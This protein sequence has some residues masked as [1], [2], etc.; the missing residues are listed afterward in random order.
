MS[1]GLSVFATDGRIIRRAP[2]PLPL[3]QTPRVA[4]VHRSLVIG[5]AAAV[6]KPDR[7][8]EGALPPGLT[9][10][11]DA[12]DA[13]LRAK[14][15]KALDDP[16][17]SVSDQQVMDDAQAVTDQKRN[18]RK[19]NREGALC[20]VCPDVRRPATMCIPVHMAAGRPRLRR[21]SDAAKP[22]TILRHLRPG[23]LLQEPIGAV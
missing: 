21:S 16:R 17:P 11:P 4:I 6:G 20:P 9:A 13:W 18:A 5:E 8:D 2:P 7:Q 23:L 12:Y 22:F 10:D 15:Q 19:L 3:V 14:V 1:M